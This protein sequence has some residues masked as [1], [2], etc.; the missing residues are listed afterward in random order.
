MKPKKFLIFKQLFLRRV[1]V[2]YKVV[3]YEK[4]C[5]ALIFVPCGAVSYKVSEQF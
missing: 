5:I 2:S 4:K 3:S 1:Q